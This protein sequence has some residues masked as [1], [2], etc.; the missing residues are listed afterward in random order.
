M[1]HFI[2]PEGGLSTTATLWIANNMLARPRT[3]L[4]LS[5]FQLPS[6]KNL[7]IKADLQPQR[8]LL[9]G[10]FLKRISA[11]Y[12]FWGKTKSQTIL[13][14][15]VLLYTFPS[16][17]SVFKKCIHVADVTLQSVFYLDK[18]VAFH[19]NSNEFTITSNSIN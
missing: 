9:N 6:C 8:L 14:I 18:I 4:A 11:G 5:F 10:S 15:N 19:P 1:E 7:L 16:Q 2:A 17:L 12:I 13:F 3:C